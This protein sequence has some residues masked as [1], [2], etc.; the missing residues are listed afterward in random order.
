MNTTSSDL[1]VLGVGAAT[2]DELW[3]VDQFRDSEC[4]HE[5][6]AHA[7]MGGGPVATALCVL[8][9]LGNRTALID[10][11]GE[12]EV[13]LKITSDLKRWNVETDLM[14]YCADAKSAR[15]VILVRAADGARQIYFLPSNVEAP[16]LTKAMRQAL[17]SARLLHLNGRHE[18]LARQMVAEARALEVEI[19][20][21]GGAGR[22]REGIRDLVQASHVRI[23]SHD[24]AVS[25]SGSNDLKVMF[26]EL[27]RPPARIVVITVGKDGCY[28]NTPDGGIRHLKPPAVA[29][30][31]TTGCGDVFHGAFLHGWIR[32]WPAEQCAS[33]ANT[34][35]ALNAEG[36]GGRFVLNAH[37]LH[38]MAT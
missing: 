28:W 37:N 18:L 30:V 29:V 10:S 20:F 5:A 9:Q 35:A 26:Q 19:S 15:A 22:Y 32:G 33:Q 4:V 13:G 16:S 27:L 1:L 6:S 2:W 24:F 36:V 23:V 3:R 25:Y 8:S 12:D 31:D 14:Q 7:A 21:D 17:A 34:F 38:L 11:C